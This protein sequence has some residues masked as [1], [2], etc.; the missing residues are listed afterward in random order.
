MTR[1]TR[2]RR[3]AHLLVLGLLVG[4]MSC[5][6]GDGGSGPPPPPPDQPGDLTVTVSSTGVAGAAFKLTVTGPGITVPSVAQAG[7]LLFPTTIAN[8]LRVIVAGPETNG[9]LMRFRVPD[10]ND[11]GQYSVVLEEVAALDG[12]LQPTGSYT[13]TLTR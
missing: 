1:N 10:V 8:G 6:G 3:G 12:S 2:V 7:Q 9:A 11:I 4:G 13:A 5:G